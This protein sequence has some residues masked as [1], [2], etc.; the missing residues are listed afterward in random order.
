MEGKIL[1]KNYLQRRNKK[2][3]TVK[4]SPKSKKVQFQ[5][6]RANSDNTK[7]CNKRKQLINSLEAF[8]LI[9]KGPSIN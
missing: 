5:N 6:K 4:D 9:T 1:Q 8:N 2:L 3:G 7:K